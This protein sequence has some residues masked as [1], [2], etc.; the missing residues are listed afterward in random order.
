MKKIL[1]PL[2]VVLLIGSGCAQAAKPGAVET[3]RAIERKDPSICLN[4]SER[5]PWYRSKDGDQVYATPKSDC[6]FAFVENT[7]NVRDCDLIREN[8]GK[9]KYIFCINNMAR[10]HSDPTI[11][12]QRKE[13]ASY[14]LGYLLCVATATLDPEKCIDIQKFDKIGIPKEKL[15][16]DLGECLLTV[17]AEKQ[18]YRVC[19]KI[20]GEEFGNS[21]YGNW[22][23]LRNWCLG[24][25]AAC[26]ES[27]RTPKISTEALC[28]LMVEGTR[29]GSAKNLE[30]ER[31]QQRKFG[32]CYIPKR[33]T[34][35]DE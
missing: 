10:V 21:I 26:D 35:P 1:L 19:E 13:P 30:L 5:T 27:Q 8:L 28:G 15:A 34:W 24:R 31:C 2:S 17:G 20:N 16:S 6:L 7:N 11:C 32:D 9:D 18:D 33:L 4:L 29:P 25:I 22:Q 3:K 12:D 23:E 14:P